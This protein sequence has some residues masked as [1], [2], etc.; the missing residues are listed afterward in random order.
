MGSLQLFVLTSCLVPFARMGTLGQLLAFFGLLAAAA[1]C[2]RSRSRSLIMEGHRFCGVEDESRGEFVPI[3]PFQLQKLSDA[4]YL[5]DK[6]EGMAVFREVFDFFKMSR[7]DLVFDFLKM[8]REDPDNPEIVSSMTINENGS[9]IQDA[10]RGGKIDFLRLLLEHGV[11]P[12]VGTTAVKDTPIELAAKEESEKTRTEMLT[13]FA[14]FVEL[15][16]EIKIK[17]N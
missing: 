15:P 1:A 10:V 2:S 12:S 7:E 11:D 6:E 16:Q 4:M 14:E 13:L 5:E 8:P 9:V 3:V 17:S